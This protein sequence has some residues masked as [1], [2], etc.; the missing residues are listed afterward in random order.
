MTLPWNYPEFA[1]D[2]GDTILFVYGA[3]IVQEP[4]LHQ[5]KPDWKRT[6]FVWGRTGAALV[7]T[8][9]LAE[10]GKRVQIWPG[11]PTFPSG[12]MA[13]AAAFCVSLVRLR[14][15]RWAWLGV[16]LLPAMAWALWASHAHDIPEILG[17]L[18]L[19]ILVAWLISLRFR[20]DT[21]TPSRT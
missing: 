9:I 6:F 14:G 19:G 3:L 11:H 13:Q 21:A 12:H 16:P 15:K 2:L 5:P 20:R 1:H 8:A 7:L 4:L 10:L 18:V 17:G